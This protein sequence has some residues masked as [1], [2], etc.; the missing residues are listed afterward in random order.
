M[1][2]FI[3][4]VIAVAGVIVYASAGV[5]TEQPSTQPQIVILQPQSQQPQSTLH[6]IYCENCGRSIPGDSN[7]CPYCGYKRGGR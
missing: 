3:G 1:L 7:L 6:T 5:S 4:L 2:L